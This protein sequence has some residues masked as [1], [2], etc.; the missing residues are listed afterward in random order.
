[1]RS[2]VRRLLA[3]AAAGGLL[4]ASACGSE[5]TADAEIVM[6][7][8]GISV[9]DTLQAGTNR[10]EV[11]VDGVAHHTLIIC[12]ADLE[13]G[14]C[15]DDPIQQRIVR[16][17]PARDPSLWEGPVRSLVLGAE[18]DA[19]VEVDLTPGTYRF[20]CGIVN[21]AQWGMDRLVEVTPAT[22]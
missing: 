9:P 17:P 14:T 13:T 19:A 8:Y 16:K 22:G 4:L 2:R 21:H 18:W 6:V 5:P 3:V 10:L 7:D 15:A 20:Y 1:M 11:R 12:P